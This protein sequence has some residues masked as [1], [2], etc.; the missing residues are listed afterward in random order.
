M[1][2]PPLN[3]GRSVKRYYVAGEFYDWVTDPR[4]LE[5]IF[6]WGRSTVAKRLIR[7]LGRSQFAL[8]IGCGTGLITRYIRSSRIVGVDINR[9]NLDR[10]KRRIPDADFVQCDVE[11]LP[12]RNDLA[13]FAVCTEVVE[14]LYLPSV[15]IPMYPYPG[16]RRVIFVAVLVVVLVFALAPSITQGN[17]KVHIY[18]L[19]TR[20]II[21]H[22]YVKFANLQFHTYGFG[23]SAGWVNV[24]ETTP[25]IDLIPM[26]SQFLPQIVASAQITSG[27]YDAIRLFMTNSTALVGSSH[28]SLSNT[29]TL[30]ANFTFPVPPNGF[31]DVLLLVSF[32]ESLVLA[33]PAALSVQVVQTSVV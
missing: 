1:D 16:W 10:A 30:S 20:G 11:H 18:G 9:W 32:D 6:H 21:D 17:I 19:T 15:I 14:H 12:L 8:D 26:T 24:T 31:G 2:A 7:R 29:P 28:V 13:D 25:I 33:N 5:R 22:L 3:D 23:S 27:R 4:A